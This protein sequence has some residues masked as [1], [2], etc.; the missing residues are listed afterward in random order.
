[1]KLRLTFVA[2]VVFFSAFSGRSQSFGPGFDKEEYLEML[3]VTLITHTDE[4]IAPW[5]E[6]DLPRPTHKMVYRSPEVGLRNRWDLWTNGNRDA[7]ISVRGTTADLVSWLENGYAA[8]V[9][10]TG[11]L[12]LADD[13]TFDYRLADNPRAT[14]HVGWLTGMAYL[15]R[16][17]LPKMDSCIAAGIR[18]FYL[19]GHSQGGAITY[20]LTA[21]LYRLQQTGRFPA[22]VKFKT[23]CSAAPKPGNLYF[24]YDYEHLTGNWAYTVINTADWVPEVPFSLQT[25]DDFNTVNPFTDAKASIKKQKFPVNLVM[26]MLYNQM[27]RPANKALKNYRKNLGKRAYKMVTRTLP[28]YKEPVFADN[29]NYVRTGTCILLYADEAYYKLFPDDKAQIF[30]HHKMQPYYYLAQKLDDTGKK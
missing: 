30:M 3:R 12:H 24:A 5:K 17:I 28:Q 13:F 19:T 18:R 25:K 4:P 27:T 1:M 21:H 7:M 15:S 9:P 23:Y 16:D 22:D 20:L 26:N 6:G 10:A 14:V 8:M 11:S 2:F 29:N